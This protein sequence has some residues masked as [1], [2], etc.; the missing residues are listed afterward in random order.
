[1]DSVKFL[2]LLLFAGLIDVA[3]LDVI[4]CPEGN[5]N[6]TDLALGK[7]LNSKEEMNVSKPSSPAIR[8][9]RKRPKDISDLR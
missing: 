7:G 6:V 4:R 8:V 5:E 9:G 3:A 1:M 2:G